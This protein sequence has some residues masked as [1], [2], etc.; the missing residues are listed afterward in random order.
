MP[1]FLTAACAT[2]FSTR[3]R[4]LLPFA[5]RLLWFCSALSSFPEQLRRRRKCTCT[6][7]HAHFRD[8]LL[9]R[10]YSQTGHFRQPHHRLDAASWLRIIPFSLICLSIFAVH[11]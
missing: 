7:L 1:F 11:A 3:R 6:G 2:W 9:R 4:Y 8:Y 10:I 5:E